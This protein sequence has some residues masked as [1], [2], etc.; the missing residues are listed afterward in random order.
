MFHSWTPNFLVVFSGCGSG[1]LLVAV[2]LDLDLVAFGVCVLR[3]WFGFLLVGSN[4]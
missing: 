4:S 1:C 3:L 2:A